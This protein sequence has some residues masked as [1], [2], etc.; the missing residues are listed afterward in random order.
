M[1]ERALVTLALLGIS[2][3]SAR[4]AVV[5]GPETAVPTDSREQY[6]RYV[7]FRPANGATVYLNPPRMS[8]H[9]APHIDP[10]VRSYPGNRLF[11]LQIASTP[12]FADPEVVIERTSVNFYNFL[13]ALRGGDTW[14]WRVCYDPG[15]DAEAW[16]EVRRF[17]IA[18]DAVE[19]D[20]SGLRDPASLLGPHSRL[21]LGGA[22]RDEVL[23]LAATDERSAELAAHII[24]I[25]DRTIT[26]DW[27]QDFWADDAEARNYM[28]P[29]RDMVSVAFAYLLTGD[30]RY[31]GVKERFL[32]V[33]SWPPGGKSSPEGMAGN[34]K[35]ST[36]L[37]EY[38]GLIYDWLYDEFTPE[39]RAVIRESLE[40]RIAHTMGS[41]AWKRGQG[42]T[43]RTGSIALLCGSHPY[44]NLMVSVAGMLAIADESEVA[45]D[46]LEVALHYL[47]GI[48][49]GMGEDE[50]WNE[51]PGYGNGKMKW[52]TDATWYAQSAL[53]A[54]ELGR[55]PAYDALCDFFA[56]I[57]PVGAEHSSFGNRGINEIDWCSSRIT[58]FRRMAM[59][60]GNPVAMQNWL[61]TR[62]RL[63]EL[64]D[65]AIP[66]PFSP[67]IDYCLSAHAAE[68]AP[69]VED[70]PVRLFPLAGWVTVSSAPPSD[71]A[72]Q[73]D[74]VS[75][76]FHCRPRGGYSHSFRS[77]NAF[78]IHAYGSTITCAGGTTSN[79]EFFANHTMSHNTVLVGGGEQLGSTQY[80]APVIG[81]IS[82]FARDDGWVYWAGD[83]TN[84][85]APEQGLGRFVRHVLFVDDA[86]FVIFDDLAVAEGAP[87]TTFQWLYHINPPV[88]LQIDQDVAS[89]DYQ[90][91]RVLV[92]VQHLPQMGPLSITNRRGA[93]G[94]VNPI[95]GEEVTA[96]DKWAANRE[97]IRRPQPL[98]AHHLWV[99]H[100]QPVHAGNFL[101]VIV[102]RLAEDAPPVIEAAGER[103][104]RVTFRG[105]TRT[106]AFRAMDGADIV[107][108]P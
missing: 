88:A 34:D 52:L 29:C 91:G 85:Y 25:A 51:G 32:T 86:Y 64:R 1:T 2:A 89:I 37:T 15:T 28:S 53:P 73:R 84:A 100:A 83:A 105:A 17:R 99:T 43:V 57:T 38:L 19:W 90:I 56:R 23:A 30:A 101:A 5:L 39:E 104:V 41:F 27:Y 3:C 79:Q 48:T 10:S 20:R 81:R 55:N 46:A 82:R 98:D 47:I 103:A 35:W 14:Y 107:V 74:A 59:L 31:A 75:M 97:D 78:D 61:A 7:G 60:T 70:D 13:P 42:E 36:H 62:E 93:E 92:R 9:Y 106:I 8:W 24:G 58:N 45:R 18:D 21:L 40:W 108:L 94:M 65:G 80:C 69:C 68:P 50:G 4:A 66:Q 6:A 16:S 22:R 77:E 63:I 49:N 96:N 33:A 71:Y 12:D 54:L 72:A 67:W 102:P 76:T 11:T 44:E 87:P 95:T 26:R